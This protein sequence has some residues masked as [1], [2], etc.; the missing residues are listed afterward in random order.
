MDNENKPISARDM[1]VSALGK[2]QSQPRVKSQSTQA[3][4]S[5]EKK[6]QKAKTIQYT[7][8]KTKDAWKIKINMFDWNSRDFALYILQSYSRRYGQVY[9]A[10]IVGVVTYMG[11]VRQQL[12]NVQGFCDNVVF[13][14]YIDFFFRKWSDYFKHKQKGV[15]H[16]HYLKRQ[17]AIKQF[18]QQYRYPSRLEH[19]QS[20]H[21]KYGISK[22]Q[23]DA[24]YANGIKSFLIQFG[25]VT[26]INYLVMFQGKTP[27]QGAKQV[28]KCSIQIY[29]QN[30]SDYNKV[31]F[32]TFSYS[33]YPASFTVRN[34]AQIFQAI[35]SRTNDPLFGQIK[36]K[37]SQKW[38]F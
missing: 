2:S 38:N 25:I 32:R 30:V 1:I 28:A 16:V 35:N 5:P 36:F 13:K 27:S 9:Q 8:I 33:P 24:V 20:L 12:A 26:A 17:Q 29:K 31:K 14:D 19:Y 15:W 7:Q 10:N 11:R 23:L 22:E 18:V 21:G 3:V 37:E 34:A 4:V 6:K